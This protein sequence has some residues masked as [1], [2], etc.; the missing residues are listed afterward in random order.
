MVHI[1][2]SV[3]K[4]MPFATG[5]PGAI[6]VIVPLSGGPARPGDNKTLHPILTGIP[7]IIFYPAEKPI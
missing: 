1:D 7:G 5:P 4:G 6:V 2:V 3:A